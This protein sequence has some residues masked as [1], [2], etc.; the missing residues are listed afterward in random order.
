MAYLTYFDLVESLIVSSYGGPQDAEQ[1]DIRQ[2]VQRAYDEVTT[3]RDWAY[4]SVHGRLTTTTGYTTGTV[5]IASGVVTLTGG[6]FA[7]AG[8]TAANAKYWGLRVADRIYPIKSYSSATSLTVEDDFAGITVPAGSSYAVY[9]TT[10]P[11]PAD[12]RDLDEPSD[13]FNWWSG[14]Y[15]SPDQAMKIAR[16]SHSVGK[17]YHW[18]V[19]KDPA[20][21]GYAIQ[22]VGYPNRVESIDYVYRRRARPLR[23]SGHEANSRAGT[24]A[25]TGTSVTLSGAS[26]FV[27]GFVGAVLRVGDTSNHPGP[28][29]SMTP[30]ASEAKIT[31]VGSSTGLTTDVSGTVAG[32][33]KYLITDPADIPRHAYTA[34]S[35]C[36]EYWLARIR[37]A[38]V[39]KAFAAYQRDMRLALEQDQLTPLSG[40]SRQV[41]HSGGWRAPLMP[42]NG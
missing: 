33:T 30:Y 23:Y 14:L 34:L 13:E 8:I 36:A 29:E 20:S 3:A 31:A 10:Y 37:G 2:A 22:L 28:I 5:E 32:S 39:D 4:Y 17:P 11:L 1:R 41:W 40:R 21:S 7:T 12:F 18:T 42:D 24:I 25:R 15:V 35:S 38:S 19:I 6:S 27:D 9:R 16:I 26:T